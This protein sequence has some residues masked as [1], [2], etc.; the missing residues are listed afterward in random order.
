MIH[1]VDR[2]TRN[3][4]LLTLL[5]AA[6]TTVAVISPEKDRSTLNTAILYVAVVAA[7]GSVA[8]L[9]GSAMPLRVIARDITAWR[10]KRRRHTKWR[11]YH[12]R[13]VDRPG[14]LTIPKDDAILNQGAPCLVLV[15]EPP[16]RVLHRDPD[17]SRVEKVRQAIQGLEGF[18]IACSVSG[19]RVARRPAQVEMEP[20]AA[21][22]RFP[23]DYFGRRGTYRAEWTITAPDGTTVRA[24]DTIRLHNHG[25]TRPAPLRRLVARARKITHHLLG[26]D[27]NL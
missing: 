18:E 25:Y 4:G 15:V 12:Y 1:R 27:L 14:T 19:R 26:R 2:Q 23:D 10:E 8:F 3:I 13:G 9:L 22:A 24:E 11:T 6:L 17:A 20:R 21:L 16:Q 7:I 5:L